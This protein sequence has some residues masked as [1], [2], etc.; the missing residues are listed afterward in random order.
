MSETTGI[1]LFLFLAL[2]SLIV[3]SL[4]NR[5]QTRHKMIRTKVR[6]LRHRIA[7]L[8]E[9]CGSIEAL[10]E[11][12]QVPR[13]VNDEILDLIASVQRLDP[14]GAQMETQLESAQQLADAFQQNRRQQPLN[15]MMPSDAK[16]AK[17]KF[18]LTE[19]G[20][21]VRRHNSL[22][23]LSGEELES[24]LKELSWAH[25]MVAVISLVSQGHRASARGHS[26]VA[27]GFYR[28]AQN[29]LIE[30]AVRDERR[31]QLIRELGE[32]QN[33]QRQTLSKEVMPEPQQ[34]EPPVTSE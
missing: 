31:H 11:T 29:I 17:H 26:V 25:L 20:R 30:S 16:I 10:L 24:C 27:F 34:P 15:R 8:T 9:I 18:Q 2:F 13:L 33:N 21:L 23:R 1:A 6:Q 14:S 4:I 12:T 22:G 3:V 28:K 32:M 5:F 19:A 7:E